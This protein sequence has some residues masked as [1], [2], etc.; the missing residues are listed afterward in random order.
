MHAEICPICLGKGKIQ[1]ADDEAY[2]TAINI[3]VCHG[4]WG[5]GWVEVSDEPK[6]SF[7]FA[8]Y[9][10]DPNIKPPKLD[11]LPRIA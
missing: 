6:V 3:V 7:S 1:Q 2:C 5:R 4:C 9:E 8:S 10:P 11:V